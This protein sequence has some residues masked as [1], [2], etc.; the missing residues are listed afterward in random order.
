MKSFLQIVHVSGKWP[1]LIRM[2]LFY[3]LPLLLFSAMYLNFCQI[4]SCNVRD[5]RETEN[6]AELG[7]SHGHT[8]GQKYTLTETSLAHL[9]ACKEVVSVLERAKKYGRWWAGVY[10]HVA[11]A[12]TRSFHAVA[13]WI[14]KNNFP[15][16]ATC[17]EEC[18][19]S[20]FFFF[21]SPPLT[22]FAH[23]LSLLTDLL[24][25]GVMYWLAS[26]SHAV[27]ANLN[28]KT[29]SHLVSL[30]PLCTMLIHGFRHRKKATF[31]EENIPSS[32][33][34][35]FMAFQPNELFH[36]LCERAVHTRFRRGDGL[37]PRPPEDQAWPSV[38]TVS[39][40][41]TVIEGL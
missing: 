13:W 19:F 32:F 15:N 5:D 11:L 37:Q 3:R 28:D 6:R 8:G 26:T 1:F 10:H 38:Q 12:A 36:S 2:D 27:L 9:W 31:M 21:S 34:P 39:S 30:P 7:I 14:F 24:Q 23:T 17:I 20:F 25:A 35:P 29:Q 33:L 4:S 41:T 40:V 22:H 16:G 18:F